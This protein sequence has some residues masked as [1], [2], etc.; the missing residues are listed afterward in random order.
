MDN[1]A[2][3]PVVLPEIGRAL[4]PGPVLLGRI[5]TGYFVAN[6]V[7]IPSSAGWPF[8]TGGTSG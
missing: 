6:G 8:K 4:S 1:G 5:M 2:T 3:L 7:A